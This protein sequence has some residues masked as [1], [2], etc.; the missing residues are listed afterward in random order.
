MASL[1]NVQSVLYLQGPGLLST[2]PQ[3]RSR[4]IGN[5]RK[6]IS[7]GEWFGGYRSRRVGGNVDV[8]NIHQDLTLCAFLMCLH[9][10]GSMHRLLKYFK[11]NLL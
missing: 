10:S 8:E 2:S 6:Q 1:S 5:D 3:G 4:R 9:A 7:D 11:I